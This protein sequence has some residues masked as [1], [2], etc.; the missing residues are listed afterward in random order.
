MK[1]ALML[2]GALLA[3][4][5]S[6]T[7]FAS[8]ADDRAEI[9]NLSNRYMIAVDAGDLDTVMATWAAD[10]EL[11]WAD[12]TEHGKEAIRKAMAGFSQARSKSIPEGAKSWPRSRHFILNHVIDVQGDTAKTLAYWFEITNNTPQ[13]DAQLVYF[14]H[15]EDELVRRNGH[16]LFKVR[17]VYNESLSNRALFYPGLGEKAPRK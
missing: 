5:I 11:V 6:T 4:A 2:L 17:K 14:G 3:C 8:Y 13:K 16:W 12:G 7:T 15:Y 9:E 1:H 10:G